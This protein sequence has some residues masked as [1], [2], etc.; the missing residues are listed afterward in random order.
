MSDH[1]EI[2]AFRSVLCVLFDSTPGIRST[3][4]YDKQT[5]S[6]SSTLQHLLQQQLLLLL[7][8]LLLFWLQGEYSKKT[9][10]LL[11]D[12][13]GKWDSVATRSW[14]PCCSTVLERKHG[15][16]VEAAPCRLAISWWET[17]TGQ[18]QTPCRQ[19]V[20]RYKFSPRGIK[21]T[22][23]EKRGEGFKNRRTHM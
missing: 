17:R 15:W 2:Q 11:L 21:E 22:A 4:L 3:L 18:P 23:W 12:C 1:V 14:V 6:P 7:L 10:R 20:R 16:I 19:L 8:L 5:L 13:H 9:S